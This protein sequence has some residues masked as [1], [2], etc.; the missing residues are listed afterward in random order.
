MSECRTLY[1]GCLD[2]DV[3]DDDLCRMFAEFE[4][5]DARAVLGDAGDCRGFGYVTFKT[6][7]EARRALEA[8]DGRA[9]FGARE[10]RVAPAV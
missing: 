2:H 10:L 5:V 3:G 9:A 6:P 8:F 7:H 4:V 1:V